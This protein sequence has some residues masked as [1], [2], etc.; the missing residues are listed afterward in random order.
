MYVDS[1]WEKDEVLDKALKEN[2]PFR[3]V[4]KNLTGNYKFKKE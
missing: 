4:K 3:E 1:N 2:F